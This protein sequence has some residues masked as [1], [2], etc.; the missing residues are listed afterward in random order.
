MT[1]IPRET[2]EVGTSAAMVTDLFGHLA[3][4]TQQ[5]H[6]AV[7]HRALGTVL[8]PPVRAAQDTITSTVYGLVRA[9][10]AIVGTAA[11]TAL[12]AVERTRTARPWTNTPRGR[13]LAGMLNGAV[14]DHLHDRYPQ[15]ASPMR[16]RVDG[17]DVE[18]D[19]ATLYRH[20]PAAAPR[21]VVFVHGVIETEEWWSGPARARA[22]DQT[23]ICEDFGTR[24]TRDLG[25]STV[26][27]R[28]NSGR[29]ISDNGADLAD[30]LDELIRAWPVPVRELALIGHSMGGLVARSA[31]HQAFA[32]GRVW[33]Q[34][35]R[36]VVCLGSPHTGAPLER[37]ANTVTAL[38]RSF[39]ESAPI[40]ALL[41]GRSAGI[42][43]LRHGSLHRQD[44]HGN[45]ADAVHRGVP[46]PYR[47]PDGVEHCNVAATVSRAP[48]PVGHWVGDLLVPTAS[49]LS[50]TPPAHGCVIPGLTH[51]G[52]L[53]HDAVYTQLV[54][55]LRR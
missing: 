49:A 26:H 9:G 11:V 4:T 46:Y 6:R 24:L 5:I 28:Y 30:L 3:V 32:Q 42:K 36:H 33:S 38:L 44:W 19:P 22:G 14:G 23:A 13:R 41:A 53:T 34:R 29:H 7:A 50:P 1:G 2:G 10:I 43:D 18:P 40:A 47:P 16:I 25:Y 8:P 51:R 12:D 15:L 52:L 48:G 54:D 45:D 31:L 20:Y 17:A 39:D 27:V 37:A 35:T 55:W 21:M